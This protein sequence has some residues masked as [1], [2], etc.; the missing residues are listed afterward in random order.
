MRTDYGFSSEITHVIGIDEVGWGAIAGPL[1]VGG[2]I[3]EIGDD[4]EWLDVKDSKRYTTERSRELAYTNLQRH[5]A[6]KKLEYFTWSVDPR[7]VAKSPAAALAHAQEVVCSVLLGDGT[8][9]NVKAGILVDGTKTIEAFAGVPSVAI[10]KA[11]AL[12]K[13]VSAASV[14]AKV[15]RDHHMI[16]LGD[17]YPEYEFFSHKGYA[18][19]RHLELLKLHG[20]LEEVH[21]TNVAK[22][23]EAGKSYARKV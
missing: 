4:L 2:C 16:K 19:P 22:V 6:E 15:E 9:P 13:V 1:T 20:Y 8:V 17:I 23:R 12:F 11:D 18:T 14:A 7:D 3:L 21:R 10:P 5:Q